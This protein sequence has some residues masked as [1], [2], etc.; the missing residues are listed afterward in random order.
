MPRAA[1][2][3]DSLAEWVQAHNE[4]V[5][6]IAYSLLKNVADAE[7]AVQA[8]FSTLAEKPILPQP[9]SPRAYLARAA[10]N[11][12]KNLI[13]KESTRRR[14]E[15]VAR[16]EFRS[17]PR[18]QDPREA[19][20]TMDDREAVANEVDRLPEKLRLP[21]LLHFREGLKY[22]E[23]ARALECPLGT[24]AR[25]IAD[26]KDRLR[27]R[28]AQTGLASAILA[29]GTV[30][31]LLSQLPSPEIPAGLVEKVMLHVGSRSSL[32]AGSTLSSPG[33]SLP[34]FFAPAVT[35]T[36]LLI[37]GVLAW[38]MVDPVVPHSVSH[39][40]NSGLPSLASTPPQEASTPAAA[41]PVASR[42]PAASPEFGPKT[43]T[44]T[45]GLNFSA[46]PDH[47]SSPPTIRVTATHH[48]RPVSGAH[49]M[50]TDRDHDDVQVRGVPVSES[51][52][53]YHVAI[54]EDVWEEWGFFGRSQKRP[55][56][57]VIPPSRDSNHGSTSGDPGGNTPEESAVV[58]W[59]HPE[60]PG[61]PYQ[62]SVDGRGGVITVQAPGLLDTTI[63]IRL[64]DARD[65]SITVEMIQPQ[66]ISGVVRGPDGPI[67]GATLQIVARF[68]A[69]GL[70]MFA[71]RP[72][73]EQERE[74]TT[75]S[76]GNFEFTRIQREDYWVLVRAAGH[77]STR[78]RLDPS[79]RIHELTLHREAP[80]SVR[81][82]D[83]FTDRPIRGARVEL[84]RHGNTLIHAI[85]DDEGRATLTGA[86]P[87]DYDLCIGQG[88][89]RAPAYRDRVTLTEDRNT[90]LECRIS[91]SDVRGTIRLDR[92][93][94]HHAVTANLISI[95]PQGRPSGNARAAAPSY[96]SALTR[97][98]DFGRVSAGR[99]L[100]TLKSKRGKGSDEWLDHQ[101]ELS[102]RDGEHRSLEFAIS[103]PTSGLELRS[104]DSS[105][106]SIDA[107]VWFRLL[108]S[109]S[110]AGYVR[111]RDGE[112]ID[113][114]LPEGQYRIIAKAKGFATQTFNVDLR[115]SSVIP[116]EVIFDEVASTAPTI[117]NR[118]SP[119]LGFV[120][121]GRHIEFLAPTR[122]DQ[123]L[124]AIRLAL[125]EV[126]LRVDPK[127]E[128]NGFLKAYSLRGGSGDAVKL[129]RDVLGRYQYRLETDGPIVWIKRRGS[130]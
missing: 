2:E 23:V 27:A 98:F 38:L 36:T 45:S 93:L 60:P 26:A 51:P 37:L 48:G 89:A 42:A 19:L 7:D 40:R 33:D 58:D 3:P 111:V 68:Y 12:A 31:Q 100:L 90:T 120:P 125:P 86:E 128:A 117:P 34:R 18:P 22:S 92:E 70:G 87:G 4:F 16:Q 54:P 78:F 24:V 67:R 44:R 61:E 85:T 130:P 108:P 103:V 84:R 55:Q 110:S 105:G 79:A 30:D 32:S 95:D 62:T 77:Q 91:G 49:V 72:Q 123:V 94:V 73:V 76:N 29:N 115:S 113:A 20:E 14:H 107:S 116:V 52:G 129:L 57:P 9:E 11:Q 66:P 69:K 64:R 1:T 50:L 25:R 99:Y 104:K 126:D 80:L 56:N 114:A 59:S 13:R 101:Q 10:L 119:K 122:H 28:F 63:A 8:T 46:T 43:P 5:Y 47:G 118:N 41:T 102:V 127:L 65:S 53:V 39:D 15:G 106:Q 81:A 83:A 96:R 71:L 75:D 109:E 35:T 112:P 124:A 82:I 74:T 6:R 21:L 121:T 17:T 97:S 88:K